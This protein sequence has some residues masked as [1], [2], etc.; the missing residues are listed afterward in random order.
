MNEATD[1]LLLSVA[2]AAK[3]GQFMDIYQ[4]IGRMTLQVVGTT[5]FGS[6][7]NPYL[8][9]Q[10]RLLSYYL[11]VSLPLLYRPPHFC[12]VLGHHVGAEC[13]HIGPQ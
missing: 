1:L 7:L 8:G 13:A 3:Q 10:S 6:A 2:A 9:L 5:A 12:N 11:I 4:A